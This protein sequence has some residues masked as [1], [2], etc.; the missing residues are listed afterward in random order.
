MKGLFCCGMMGSVF[1]G[2]WRFFDGGL[3]TVMM[4]GIVGYEMHD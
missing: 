3:K 4:G 2:Q 1:L